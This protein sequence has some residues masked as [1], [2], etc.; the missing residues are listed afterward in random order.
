MSIIEVGEFKK[1]PSSITLAENE[2]II[3]VFSYKHPHRD[4]VH[5]DLQLLIGRKE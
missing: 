3:G 1:A 2:K 5:I 4:G